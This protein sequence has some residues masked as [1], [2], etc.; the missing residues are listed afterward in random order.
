MRRIVSAITGPLPAGPLL[1]VLLLVA[2]G[3]GL[4]APGRAAGDPEPPAQAPTV[5][6][7]WGWNEGRPATGTTD[8]LQQVAPVQVALPDA[9]ADRI[10]GETALLYFSPTCPHCRH[11][12]PELNA[13]ARLQPDLAFLGIASSRSTA[14]AVD[15]F[16]ATYSVPFP[17]VVDADGAFAWAVGA[18]STPSLLLARPAPEGTAPTSGDAVP[19]G[20]RVVTITEAYMPYSRGLAP[21]LAM[22]RNALGRTVDGPDGPTVLPSDAFRDFQGYQGTRACAA[23]HADEALSWAITHHAGAYRTL[24]ERD[25]SEDLACVGCHVVGFTAGTD[26]SPPAWPDAGGFLLADHGSPLADVGCEACH[27]PSGPHDGDARATPAGGAAVDACAGCHDKKH[28]VAFSV[29]KGMPHI[30]HYAALALTE[31]ELRARL[32]ALADGTAERPLLAFPTGPT[33]GA[34]ACKECHKTEHKGWQ[35]HDHARA[36]QTLGEDAGRGECVACHATAR[37]Y[38][39]MGRSTEVADY[40]TDEGVGCEACHGPGGEH[41]AEPTLENIVRLGETC[42]ECV[43][44]GI[45]TSCHD[46]QWD[47]GWQLSERLQALPYR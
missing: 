6:S 25:R 27:G 39:G 19:D 22:R 8:A 35:K 2:A 15:E 18:R 43:L 4:L 29:E 42:P 21:V 31:D 9:V 32:Q 23:C 41:A 24:W 20:H 45:C 36:V 17:I 12:M 47:P 11:A 10:Q 3:L 28:S 37:A 1:A 44:E 14:D 13:L 40:R 26:G 5:Q 34:A 30:D 46:A 33:V 7:R 16:V 38:G